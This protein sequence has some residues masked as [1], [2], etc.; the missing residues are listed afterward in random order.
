[1]RMPKINSVQILLLLIAATLFLGH[2]AGHA[3]AQWS[4]PIVDT[5]QIPCYDDVGQI[6]CPR[7]GEPFYG[8]D[9]QYQGQQMTF[10]DNGDGRHRQRL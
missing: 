4:S 9:A 5:G 6:P 7:P 8:Q 10:R 1:M 3:V 2:R